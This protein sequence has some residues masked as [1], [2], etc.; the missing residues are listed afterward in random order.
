MDVPEQKARRRRLSWIAGAGI[1][2]VLV[3]LVALSL[4][5]RRPPQRRVRLADGST[6]TVQAVT[7]G[8][9]ERVVGSPLQT[10][11]YRL[12]P[13]P[14]NEWSGARAYRGSGPGTLTF[15]VTRAGAGSL[16]PTDLEATVFDEHGN[17]SSA[18]RPQ[19]WRVFGP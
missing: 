8:T 7:W 9:E 13:A 2:L 18:V 19:A 16:M 3:L 10:L 5:A 1:A 4:A 15:W 17:E 11:L 12:L 14:R 6:V